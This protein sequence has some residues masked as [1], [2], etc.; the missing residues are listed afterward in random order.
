MEEPIT[1]LN[2]TIIR[3][4]VNPD[5]SYFVKRRKLQKESIEL[6]IIT[7]APCR[8]D[9]IMIASKIPG[10]KAIRRKEIAN[11]K[12]IRLTSLYRPKRASNLAVSSPA[13][14]NNP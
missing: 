4:T 8:P 14:P 3:I 2:A 7:E 1:L 12:K 10:K 5:V 9:E 6:I 11:E 13:K